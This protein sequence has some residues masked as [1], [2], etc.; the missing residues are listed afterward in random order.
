M[1]V[2]E[3]Y[4]KEIDVQGK[5]PRATQSTRNS[6]GASSLAHGPISATDLNRASRIYDSRNKP[7]ENG[8]NLNSES[9]EEP[10]R[11]SF[12]AWLLRGGGVEVGIEIAKLGWG[13]VKGLCESVGRVFT[14]EFWSELG[15]GFMQGYN[16]FI[17]NPLEATWNGIKAVGKFVWDTVTAPIQMIVLGAQLI[18]QGRF[19]E[20]IALILVGSAL[21]VLTAYGIGAIAG[22][23]IAA[24][25][26]ALAARV[27]TQAA[28]RTVSAQVVKEIA[29]DVGTAV[30]KAWCEQ[31]GVTAIKELGQNIATKGASSL[32][33]AIKQ[34]GPQ[35][36]RGELRGVAREI[37][38]RIGSEETR[39]LLK[40]PVERDYSKF[41]PIAWTQQTIDNCKN[42]LGISKTK[43]DYLEKLTENNSLSVMLHVRDGSKKLQ[44]KTLSE[45][46]KELSLSRK[47]ELTSHEQRLLTALQGSDQ[48]GSIAFMRDITIGK[49]GIKSLDRLR[50]SESLQERAAELMKRS[51]V[52]GELPLDQAVDPKLAKQVAKHLYRQ[53]NDRGILRVVAEEMD[54]GAASVI[55]WANKRLGKK[56]FEQSK[57]AD[58]FDLKFEE[59][60]CQD[61]ENKLVN[62]INASL[63]D[64]YKETLTAEFRRVMVEERG[65]PESWVDD[66]VE[67][68]EQG[69]IAG[70]KDELG[71]CTSKGLLN[72]RKA[73]RYIRPRPDFEKLLGTGG[74]TT[75]PTNQLI[76]LVTGLTLAPIIGGGPKPTGGLGGAGGKRDYNRDE[77]DRM[78][79]P[80]SDEDKGGLFGRISWLVQRTSIYATDAYDWVRSKVF[81]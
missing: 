34:T 21:T 64:D 49:R 6:E 42:A 59:A 61:A 68:F 71:E 76:G 77:S 10:K 79:E 53:S 26:G 3:N 14:K 43:S 81:G 46:L 38:E 44:Q 56:A 75:S 12:G 41:K 5:L 72:A 45:Y 65:L 50:T 4:S 62:S 28:V 55:N 70:M 51:A 36:G 11:E 80:K 47:E 22:A 31:V 78:P 15:D 24:L 48:R 40:S 1:E 16:A 37:G 52:D 66:A 73:L 13:M 67:S 7:S 57:K 25:S 20:G 29:R 27:A 17:K 74:P 39:A 2:K 60:I 30:A 32:G 33:L 8:S 19:A 58:A 69:R 23:G 18:A 63:G 35:I 54:Y 9:V